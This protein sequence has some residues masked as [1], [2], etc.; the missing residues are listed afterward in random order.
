M[1]D[2]R[3][4]D[5]RSRALKIIKITAAMAI[6]LVVVQTSQ[7]NAN[8]YSWTDSK[9]V[10]HFSNVPPPPS[11]D[12]AIGVRQEIAYDRAADEKRWD[13]DQKD[14]EALKQELQESEKQK[15][16]ENYGDEYK[17]DRKSLAEKIQKEKFRLELEISRLE[18]MPATSFAKNLDGKRAAIAY[19]QTRLKELETDPQRYFDLQ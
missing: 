8:I 2:I 18:K 1:K 9:G 19:Y 12:A 14:W 5:T 4:N 10:K 7:L 15:I 16:E 13:L 11:I 17:E 3:A 6:V